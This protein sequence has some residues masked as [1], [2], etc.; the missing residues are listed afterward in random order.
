MPPEYTSAQLMLDAINVVKD[1]M[2]FIV[3]AAIAVGA[4]AFVA[5]WFMD[6]ID[7]AGKTFGRHK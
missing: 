1:N 5:A 7:L 2:A 4:I 6:S 3:P